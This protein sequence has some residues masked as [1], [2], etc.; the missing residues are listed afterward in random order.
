MGLDAL[1]WRENFL[2]QSVELRNIGRCRGR[3]IVEQFA[4]YPGTTLNG[5]GVLAIA[6]H[7]QNAGHANES[8]AGGLLG[9]LHLAE[10]VTLHSRDP[11]IVGENV[12]HD[13]VIRLEKAA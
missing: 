7:G 1:A 6:P 5:A 4:K 2:R 13:H 3:R 8:T 9:K 12:V 10:G 11:V